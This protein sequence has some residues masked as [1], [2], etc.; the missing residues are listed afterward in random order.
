MQKI[1]PFLWFNDQAEEAANFYTSVFKNSK[2]GT[3]NRYGEDVPGPKGKVMTVAFELDGQE[4]I[5]LNGGPD[6]SFTEA[7]SFFVKC[8]DQA[9]VDRYWEKLSEGGQVQQC[10]WLKDKYGVSW[11]IVP[12]ILEKLMNDPDPQKANRVT[13]AMLQMIKIDIEGLKRA[14]AQA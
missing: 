2:I 1:T 14:Y 9:E 4:L 11:Q 10:G 8:E 7:I 5:A 6:F 12:T 3:I 13:Q